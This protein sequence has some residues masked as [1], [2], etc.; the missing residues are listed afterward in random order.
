M[1]KLRRAR[2]SEAEV[3]DRLAELEQAKQRLEEQVAKNA[4]Q[5]KALKEKEAIDTAALE[6]MVQKAE[7]NLVQTTVREDA[8]AISRPHLTPR[9]FSSARRSAPIRQSQWLFGCKQS[10][11][12]RWRGRIR[13]FRPRC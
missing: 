9:L 1:A 3:R 10:W 2:E 7:S 5:I 6:K 12:Q 13:S 8:R 11:R 4:K